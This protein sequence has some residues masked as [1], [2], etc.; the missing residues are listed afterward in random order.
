MELIIVGYGNMAKAILAGLV[1]QTKTALNITK[2][3][4]IGR[5]PN[6]IESWLGSF[7]QQCRSEFLHDVSY[8]E[9]YDIHC[10]DKIVLL[11]CKPYNLDSFFFH[12]RAHIVYSV[13][14]GVNANLLHHAVQA[15][16]YVLIMPNVGAHYGVS[17]SAVLWKQNG[18]KTT[19][20]KEAGKALDLMMDNR[21]LEE[22]CQEHARIFE[23][24]KQFVTS[25]GSCEF[26]SSE[27]E[28]LA[29]IATN[30]SSPALLALVA[31]GIINAGVQQGLSKDVSQRL[32]Q[33]TFEGVA[34]LLCEKTPQEIKD[35]VSSPGGTTI[36]ALIHCDEQSVQ[37]SI[38]RACIKAVEKAKQ[39]TSKKEK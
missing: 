10:E 23:Q 26:V 18:S 16:H 17:S 9:G 12:G 20:I 14:A 32:V 31:Q 13:L 29:S 19:T 27:Q 5:N 3:T 38:T 22:S 34:Q 1:R 2:I 30:G 4:I 35:L 11:A 39:H 36:E 25:F 37:G 21:K 8:K 7:M 15:Y 33:K 28:L 24:I 6:K